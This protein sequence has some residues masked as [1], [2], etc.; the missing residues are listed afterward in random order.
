MMSTTSNPTSSAD[1]N[2][3]C[4]VL[5]EDDLPFVFVVVGKNRKMGIFCIVSTE[6]KPA[7]V[8]KC[9]KNGERKVKWFLDGKSGSKQVSGFS[10]VLK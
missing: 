8:I 1:K 2:L 10:E 7:M 9:E 3:P 4:L 6:N 5:H